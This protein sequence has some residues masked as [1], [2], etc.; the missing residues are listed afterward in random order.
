[1]HRIA[2]IQTRTPDTQADA[3][4]ELEPLVRQAAAGG[5]RLIAT[6]EGSNLLQRDREKL[7]GV[8]AAP[9]DDAVV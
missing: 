3:L 6:P 7:Q 2:L 1:M 4:T 8:L 9:A 5:A